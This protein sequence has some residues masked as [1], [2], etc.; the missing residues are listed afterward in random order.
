MPRRSTKTRGPDDIRQTAIRM[1]ESTHTWLCDEAKKHRQTLNS[2]M[3]WRLEN[4][5]LQ[6]LGVDLQ[7][8]ISS[9]I[10]RL[11]PYLVGAAERDY[12]NDAI[13][14]ARQLADTCAPLLAAGVVKGRACE[15]MQIAL[16]RLH[17]ARH[18]LEGVWSLKTP[19]DPGWGPF[20]AALPAK[21]WREDAAPSS[22]KTTDEPPPSNEEARS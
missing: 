6:S 16:K 1:R 3:T 4:S 5:R 11:D 20:W 2:E 13:D 21:R 9:V 22:K 8:V 10:P 17:L 14:A 12:Y 18:N 15:N 19:A 7:V